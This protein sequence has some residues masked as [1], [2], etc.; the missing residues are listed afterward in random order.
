MANVDYYEVL[1]VDRSATQDEIKKA[2][3]KKARKLHPDV[4]DAPDA[5][6][7]FKQVNEAY[8]VLSDEKKRAQYDQFGTV[9]GPGGFGG[10][11]GGYTDFSD[12]FGGGG[13]GGMGDI[14][15]T[16]F[17]GGRG[18]GSRV[19]TAGRNMAIS[20]QITLEEAATG[21][22]RE[23]S[24]ER[25]APCETCDGSGLSENGKFTT[26][27]S[28]N[29][30]GVVTTMQRSILGT[31]QT[32]SPCPDCGGM[33]KTIENP[34]PD[35]EGEGRAPKTEKISIEIPKGI[36]D[37]QQI[38]IADMGEAGISGDTAGD[39][40][41]KIRVLENDF[42]QRDGDNLHTRINISMLQA[43]L[44]VT[45][46]IEGVLP[47]EDI[48][49]RVPSGTQNDDVVRV[50]DRGMPRFKSD[51]R[52]DLYAHV[53]VDIPKKLSKTEREA[54]EKAAKVF[55]EE[56]DEERGA[57]QKIKDKLS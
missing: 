21:I 22:K 23:I 13:F 24:Y 29:G 45:V 11:G 26:C 35:C 38:K 46:S 51:N 30:S 18:G 52:G 9:G 14:F 42:Y 32:Q 8:E 39:L 10:G 34:C 19:S 6:E 3:Y 55:G 33:G 54:L 2:F 28:C 5:E 48:E 47:D 56:Y 37:G 20:L 36:R 1:G 40:L 7:Q 53:W 15:E 57:F 50:K 17:G 49:I 41:V 44:G 43:A 16:F 12:I 4:N 25:L 27:P 31:I